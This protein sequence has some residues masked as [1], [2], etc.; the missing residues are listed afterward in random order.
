MKNI[1]ATIAA[2]AALKLASK[3]AAEEVI[4]GVVS[5]DGMDF[6]WSLDVEMDY[7]Y[8][9][10]GHDYDDYGTPNGRCWANGAEN[11]EYCESG[12]LDP[13]TCIDDTRCHWNPD[14]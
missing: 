8:E 3:S 1:S 12:Q 11:E 4:G 9:D 10:Y 13:E 14:Y 2:A 6:D 7:G 5:F